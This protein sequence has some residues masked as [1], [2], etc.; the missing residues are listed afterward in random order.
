[1]PIGQVGRDQAGVPHL[2]LIPPRAAPGAG[3]ELFIADGLI[4]DVTVALTRLRSISVLAAHSARKVANG[5]DTGGVV[6]RGP[7]SCFARN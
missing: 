2:A 6:S 4:D 1:M 5:E 7:T 3:D